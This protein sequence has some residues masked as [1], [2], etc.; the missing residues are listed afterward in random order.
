[1]RSTTEARLVTIFKNAKG[2][3]WSDESYDLCGP[4][5]T[6]AEATTAQLKYAERL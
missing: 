2:Y 1:M 5:K 3:W 4:Y 6:E